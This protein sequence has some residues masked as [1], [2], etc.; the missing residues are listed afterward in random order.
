MNSDLDDMKKYFDKTLQTGRKKQKDAQ[1]RKFQQKC[2]IIMAPLFD[3]SEHEIRKLTR[4]AIYEGWDLMETV[5]A[6]LDMEAARAV[7]PF[8]TPKGIVVVD[9]LNRLRE[10]KLW[11]FFLEKVR[12]CDKVVIPFKLQG[13]RDPWVIT[14][15]DVHI[16][17]A[18]NI[19]LV[20]PGPERLN[21]V[22]IMP[23]NQYVNERKEEHG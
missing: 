17:H 12:E 6:E 8:Y 13:Y 10:L 4:Q 21:N 5:K 20:V 3:C 7:D 18:Y 22:E 15:K 2:L 19:R 9:I 14:N 23:L 1:E 16:T 11:S